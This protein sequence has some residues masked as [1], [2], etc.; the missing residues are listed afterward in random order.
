[1]R[2]VLGVLR[3]KLRPTR[4]ASEEDAECEGRLQQSYGRSVRREVT[5]VVEDDERGFHANVGPGI[6]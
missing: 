5:S 3:T 6:A 1:M 4:G 2:L